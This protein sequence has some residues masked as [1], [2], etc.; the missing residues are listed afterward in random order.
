MGLE[1][2]QI[3]IENGT[4]AGQKIPVLFNPEEYTL[5]KDNNFAAQAVPGLSGPLIQFVNGNLS[6][7][8]M[9]L[10]FDTWDSPSVAKA[11]VRILTNQVVSL[12]EL[13]SKLHAPPILTFSWGSLSFLCVL[14]RASQKFIMFADTG[15]PVRARVNVTF[16][17]Y[18][19]P[20]REA[21]ETNR[22]TSDFTKLHVVR[23]GDTLSGIAGFVYD[24]PRMW[25][26][27]AIQ[28]RIADPRDL[29][30]G[31]ALQVPSLPYTDPESGEVVT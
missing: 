15:K 17:K 12:M 21:K 3:I 26:P 18:T 1:K 6:T 27:I 2:A 10:F 19:D 22:Q 14:A 7:L 25:R 30:P 23:L 31:M 29:S 13:D 20:E 8:E 28:N 9:E 11:D 16:H 5:N 24:N 4:K